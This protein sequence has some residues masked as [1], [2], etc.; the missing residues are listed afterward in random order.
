M[1]KLGSYLTKRSVNK[2]DLARKIGATK[3]RIDKLSNDDRS[4]LLL[5]EA[6]LIA[7]ALKVDVADFVEEMCGDLKLID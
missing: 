6:Y 1:T 5:S 4:K 2:S 7:L 3:Q